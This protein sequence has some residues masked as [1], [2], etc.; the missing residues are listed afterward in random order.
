MHQSPRSAGLSGL[1]RVTEHLF[2]SNGRAARDCSQVTGNGITCIIN[3]TETRGGSDPPPGVEYIHIPVSDSPLFLLRDHFDQVADKI[4]S[5]A[6]QHGRTLV[7]CNAGVSRSAAL[8]LAYLMK[9]RG[10]TLLEAHRLLKSC[11]PIVRP[12][13]GFWRQLIQYEAELRGSSSVSMV[14][15]CIGEIPDIYGEE[16]RNMVLL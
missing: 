15:S 4:Q 3:A 9:H 13:P 5:T 16:A 10:A 8:C 6:E 14:P 7:H 1:C 2:L 11:R 12:N